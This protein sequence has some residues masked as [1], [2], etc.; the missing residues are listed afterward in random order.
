MAVL[1]HTAERA[2][3][4]ALQDGEWHFVTTIRVRPP[5]AKRNALVRCLKYGW[6]V[7][8][9]FWSRVFPDYRLTAA[10]RALLEGEL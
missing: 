6:V 5:R 2:V 1:L 10:G 9:Q 7:R 3:L 4:V 8:R